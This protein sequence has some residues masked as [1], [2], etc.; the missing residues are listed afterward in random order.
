MIPSNAFQAIDSL[1]EVINNITFG[2]SIFLSVIYGFQC[3][4]K[5]IRN[6]SITGCEI[7]LM[8]LGFTGVITKLIGVW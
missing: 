6:Q 8:G 1:N 7:V 2:I 5:L 3:F 4:G